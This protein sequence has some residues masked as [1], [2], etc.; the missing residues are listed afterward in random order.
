LLDRLA[1]L[2]PPPRRHR[3]HYHG[4]FAPHSPLRKTVTACAGQA[5]TRIVTARRSA[6]GNSITVAVDTARVEP[7]A[8]PAITPAR[9]QAAFLWVRLL[10]RIYDVLPLVCPRCGGEMRLI[11]FITEPTAIGA[12]LT[13]IGESITPPPL[14]PRARAPPEFEDMELALTLDQS[15]AW[16][17]AAPPTEQPFEFN[18]Q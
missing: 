5:I 6:T 11:A 2:I 12:I 18:Q 4:V 16:D 8:A 15:P 9:R 7:T 17:L 3:H 14:A 13:H 1:A 10:A